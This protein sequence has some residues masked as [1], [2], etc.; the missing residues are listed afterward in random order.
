M[1]WI[2]VDKLVLATRIAVQCLGPLLTL[3][4]IQA[5]GWPF[6]MAM[7]GFLDLMLLEGASE[8][9]R[10]WLYF[11][12]IRLYSQGNSGSYVLTSEIYVR[13]LLS[14][15]VAGFLTAGKRT[16]V[17][18]YFGR[19][20]FMEFKPRLEKLLKEVVLVSE[21]AALAEEAEIAAAEEVVEVPAAPSS[22]QGKVKFLGDVSWGSRKHLKPHHIPGSRRS[23]NQSAPQLRVGGT[24]SDSEE[25]E[26]DDD[27]DDSEVTNPTQNDF[28]HVEPMDKDERKFLRRDSSGSLRVK[29]LLGKFVCSCYQFQY[30]LRHFQNN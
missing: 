17:A 23:S 5:R 26:D 27:D 3:C 20:T 21:L 14:M 8:F 11:T 30:L 10:H 15:V 2:I 16:A 4:C 12:N 6:C 22:R 9:E 7:W 29:D 24:G 25:E 19:R 28:S 13:L 18:M 1:K